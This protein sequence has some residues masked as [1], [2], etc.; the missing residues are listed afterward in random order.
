VYRGR[1]IPLAW[2]VVRHKS[3]QVSFEVYLPVLDQVRATIPAGRVITL[4]ADRGFLHERLLHYLKQ[5]WHFR[6]RLPGNTLVHLSPQ[7]ISALRD[8]CPPAGQ[9]RFFHEVAI[10]GA[11]IGPVHLALASLV[12]H[13]NDPWFVVSDEPTQVQTL[14]EYSLRFD[15]EESFRDAQIGRLPASD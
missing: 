13:P 12:D 1:A 5:Q 4:L 15:I 6:L 2:R 11:G 14:D 9:G 8:Q 7:H 3:T 10:L